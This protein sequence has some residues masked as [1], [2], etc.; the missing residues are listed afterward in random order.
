[1]L[2]GMIL[3]FGKWVVFSGVMKPTEFGIYATIITTTAFISFFG[4]FGLNEYLIKEGSLLKGRGL[5]YELS[6]IR[7]QVLAIGLLNSILIIAIGL[8]VVSFIG[9]N[10][11]GVAERLFVSGILL[12]NVVFNIIDAS[13]RA[14]MQF[15]DFAGMIF[16]RA[17]LLVVIG[18]AT[19]P[20]LG[21]TGVLLAEVISGF[22]AALFGARAMP[23]NRWPAICDIQI[24]TIATFLSKGRVFLGLQTSRYFTLTA[25]KWIVGWFSGGLALGQYSFL[26]ITFLGFMA[27]AGLFNAVITPKLIANFGGDGD[28]QALRDGIVRISVIFLALALLVAP[29]YLLLVDMLIAYHFQ[30]YVFDGLYLSLIFVYIGSIF[31]VIH[32]FFDGYFYSQ[33]RQHELSVINFLSLLF[34]LLAFISSGLAEGGVIYFAFSFMLAKVLL[35]L[36]V[37]FGFNRR[38]K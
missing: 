19:A 30:E 4:M 31:H 14:T 23:F 21:L 5:T 16:I 28:I 6:V 2:G 35:L 32:H 25:D 24:A 27:I 8:S 3:G 1:M 37:Y 33:S 22:I 29:I 11:I 36:L 18:L 12:I 38:S 15:I 34:F 17:I 13:L 9:V 20:S 26:L 7:N 10:N